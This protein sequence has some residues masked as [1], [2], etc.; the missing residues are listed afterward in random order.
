MSTATLSLP[1]TLELRIPLTDDQFFQ[2]CQDNPNLRFERTASG[3]LLIMS[4]TGGETGNRNI[5]L[6]FQIQA[7]SRQNNLGIAFDSSTCFKLPNGANR[8]PDAAWMQREKWTA[9][10]PEQRQRFPP[11]CPDF[12]VELR[13]ASDSLETLRAKMQE[14]LDNGIRLGWLI[15]PKT[16]QV[17]IYRLGQAVER[18]QSP[19]TLLGEDVLPHFV[20]DVVSVMRVEPI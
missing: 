10:T 11:L 4:L 14:Y 1:S 2:L 20:L 9:L 16:E 3:E 18:L 15:D 12:V 13:S 7:W 5:E 6:A 17:E 8:S 19:T